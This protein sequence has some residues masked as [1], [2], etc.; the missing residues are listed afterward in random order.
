MIKAVKNERGIALVT[1]ALFITLI[2]MGGLA[3]IAN[4]DQDKDISIK[5]M[6]STQAFFLAEAGIQRA[7]S[8][9]ENNI[10][11]TPHIT[12]YNCGKGE[13]EIGLDTSD[14]TSYIIASEGIVKA[15][16]GDVRRR[17]VLR[18]GT[19]PGGGGGS[20]SGTPLKYAIFSKGD[21]NLQNHVVGDIYVDGDFKGST[22]VNINGSV[23]VTGKYDSTSNALTIVDKDGIFH[24][25]G[26]VKTAD[27]INVKEIKCGG[28]MDFYED[29]SAEVFEVN[30]NF[31][32]KT[33]GSIRLTGSNPMK[34]KGD[35]NN[36]GSLTMRGGD[37]HAD[38][39]I[40]IG[41]GINSYSGH[42]W[43]TGAIRDPGND[44]PDLREHPNE[45]SLNVTVED[46]PV[47]I[48][49]F[50]E[51]DTAAIMDEAFLAGGESGSINIK[52]IG[53]YELGPKLIKGDLTITGINNLKLE[54]VIY[55]TGN[56]KIGDITSIKSTGYSI[57]ADKNICF[58]S[59]HMAP[60]GNPPF[61]LSTG[62]DIKIDTISRTEAAVVAMKGEVDIS[63]ISTIKGCVYGNGIS[64]KGLSKVVYDSACLKNK[65]KGVG[66]GTGTGTTLDTTNKSWTETSCK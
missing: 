56:V 9:L 21:L 1:A 35:F 38:G 55:V 36:A 41:W 32:Q 8:E 40:R 46:S 11:W 19:I 45:A 60:K 58:S 14:P 20:G 3:L 23:Q 6:Q 10:S 49:D 18:I 51:I 16:N 64:L 31:N 33:I 48:L 28:S 34:V 50:P 12:P 52:G 2:G 15:H 42:L 62:G 44:V 39:D 63:G 5:K 61:L 7:I 66:G 57:V 27:N 25:N 17:I 65:P 13:Y 26:N 54:G 53:S 37:L 30:G 4:T 22:I 43:A 59:D 47:P 29:C 24:V